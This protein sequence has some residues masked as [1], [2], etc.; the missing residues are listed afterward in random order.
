MNA[1]ETKPLKERVD[2]WRRIAA[3][4]WQYR[5]AMAAGLVFIGLNVIDGYLTNYAYHMADGMASVEA[6][7]F[8]QPFL[9]HWALSLKGVMGLGIFALLAWLKRLSPDRLFWWI[10]FGCVVFTGIIIWNMYAMGMIW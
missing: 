5:Y 3:E 6:N 10:V 9:G 7:P 2:S 8:M 4:L 1:Q